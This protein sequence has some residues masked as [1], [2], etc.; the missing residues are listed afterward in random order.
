MLVLDW[1]Y[2][3]KSCGESMDNLL[4]HCSIACELWSLVFYLFGIHWVMPHKVI[5]LFKS[6]QAMFGWHHN[7]HFWRLVPHCL[8]WCIWRERNARSFERCECS[9]LEVKSFFFALSL[10]GV[11][12]FV[13][14]LVLPL[15]FY[16]II[17]ILVLDLC[18]HSTFPMYLG[19]LFSY[20]NKIFVTYQ[21][22][23]KKKNWHYRLEVA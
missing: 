15:L 2:M 14:F 11:W 16:L 4:L 8:I 19:S 17:V 9:T 3:C 6:W 1:C 18:P 22:K 20:F 23:K 7:I 5:E 10:I 12:F 13:I 21:K